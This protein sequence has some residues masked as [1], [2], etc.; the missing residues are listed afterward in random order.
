MMSQVLAVNTA[1]KPWCGH[2]PAWVT[3]R[4]IGGNSWA[5]S[6]LALWLPGGWHPLMAL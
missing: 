5:L 1:S 2:Y 6:R 4:E 3:S